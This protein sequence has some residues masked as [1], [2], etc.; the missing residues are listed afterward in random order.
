SGIDLSGIELEIEDVGQVLLRDGG[1]LVELPRS[2]QDLEL[3]IRENSSE[4]K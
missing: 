2:Y 1:K 4:K 3:V